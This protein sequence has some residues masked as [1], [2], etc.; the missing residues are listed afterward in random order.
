MCV[1]GSSIPIEIKQ[2]NVTVV[3]TLREYKNSHPKC[4]SLGYLNINS[5]R[6]KFS[7]IPLI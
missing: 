1:I 7:D 5:I 3:K 2:N 4:V 6:N